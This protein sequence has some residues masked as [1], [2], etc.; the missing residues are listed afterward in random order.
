M[1]LLHR[2]SG[3]VVAADRV[4]TVEHVERNARL[5]CGFHRQAHRRDVRVEARPHVL[6]VEHERVQPGQRFLRRLAIGAVEAENRRAGRV[7][8]AVVDLLA[9]VG[10]SAQAVF[11]AEERAQRNAVRAGYGIDQVLAAD[12]GRVVD[13]QAD[14]HAVQVREAA[15]GHHV[16]SG[17]NERAQIHHLPRA[18]AVVGQVGEDNRRIGAVGVGDLVGRRAGDEQEEGE[19]EEAEHRTGELRAHKI[20]DS[21]SPGQRMRTV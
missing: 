18:L 13:D 2:P 10:C 17:L 21:A 4:G 16:G 12:L 1:L 9:R 8:H 5:G 14:A 6:N 19:R 3:H 7:V 15:R 20:A 11:G